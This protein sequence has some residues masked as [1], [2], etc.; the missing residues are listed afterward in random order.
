M[1]LL[2]AWALLPVP[3]DVPRGDALAV[4]DA[5]VR[6]VAAG[7]QATAS[8]LSARPLDGE[9]M[10]QAREKLLRTR[11]LRPLATLGF[12]PPKRSAEVSASDAQPVL[13]FV[14]ERARPQEADQ[15]ILADPAWW[16]AH[17]VLLRQGSKG[18]VVEGVM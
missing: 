10:A 2:A 15:R 6:A 4:A 1:A 12:E 9:G 5:F 14:I 18:W 16:Y 8:S 17:P 11:Q 3:R 13:L 7:D